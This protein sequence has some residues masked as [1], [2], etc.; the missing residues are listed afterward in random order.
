MPKSNFSALKYREEVALYKEH[1]AKLHSHQK[2]NIS[3]YAKTH[4][5][6]YKRLLRAYKNAPTRSDKKP[7]NYRLNDAQDLALERYLNAIN[8]I[9]FGIH[10][11]MIAQQ[12]Y[13]LLQESYMGPD[14]SP[15]PLGHNWARRWLQRHPKY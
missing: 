13:A 5:L 7:T 1:A 9:G 15:T 8:A 6:G 10:H 11:R 12:A 4:N 14:E 2:P 3:S